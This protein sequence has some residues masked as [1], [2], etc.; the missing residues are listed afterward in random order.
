MPNVVV[1]FRTVFCVTRLFTATET[2]TYVALI[3]L[4]VT[5]TFVKPI[6]LGVNRPINHVR[7]AIV[8]IVKCH[9]P[10]TLFV[11]MVDIS[12]IARRGTITAKRDMTLGAYF[13]LA[14][15]STIV[16]PSTFNGI[17]IAD[18]CV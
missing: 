15:L 7:R 6:S 1:L 11:N 9:E 5:R 14:P 13:S 10:H 8:C 16:S 17:N 2:N 12:F 18:V 3:C 4:Q